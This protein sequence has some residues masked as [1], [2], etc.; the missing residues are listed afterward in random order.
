M[1]NVTFCNIGLVLAGAFINKFIRKMKWEELKG[2]LLRMFPA[3]LFLVMTYAVFT[4]SALFLQNISEFSIPYIGIV[5]VIL[6]VAFLL[7]TIVL[8]VVLCV[9]SDK[10]A[11]YFNSFLFLLALGLYVQGNFLNPTFPSLD[12]APID[13]S[14]YY[15]RA[16]V[17]NLLWPVFLAAV[18]AAAVRWKSKSQRIMKW[19]SYWCVSIQ[20]VTLAVLLLTSERE[21][22]TYGISKEGEFSVGAEENIVV[23]I[24]DSLQTSV[25]KEYLASDNYPAGRLDDFTMFDNMVSGGAPTSIGLTVFMTGVEYDPLQSGKEFNEDLWEDV[26][27]YD[28]LHESNYDVRFYTSISVPVNTTL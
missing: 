14:V 28:D 21:A 6:W 27:L 16:I 20:M 7:C 18:F 19:I 25:M 26:T 4:P 9:V 1:L 12:G 5:P 10:N 13:W 22:D 2:I 3:T 24:V 8:F 23:F 15:K 17:S 11:V